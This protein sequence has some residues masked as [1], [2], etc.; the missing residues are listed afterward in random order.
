MR[1]RI[2]KLTPIGS[3]QIPMPTV[4]PFSGRPAV[5]NPGPPFFCKIV[6][7]RVVS[8]MGWNATH[9]AGQSR[10]KNREGPD[11]DS[12]VCMA[13]RDD[14]RDVGV[15]S[16]RKDEVES[17]LEQR[18]RAMRGAIAEAALAIIDKRDYGALPCAPPLRGQHRGCDAVQNRSRRF[19]RTE[20]FSP[21]PPCS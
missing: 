17:R 21:K 12:I 8:L 11:R 9:L 10:V 6:I 16:P 14:Y 7:L 2:R 4:D 3:N 15:T 19:C 18:P 5:A 13:E 1:S 20:G